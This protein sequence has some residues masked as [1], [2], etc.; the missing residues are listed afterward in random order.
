MHFSLLEKF[1]AAALIC[2]WLLYGAN[3]LGNTLVSVDEH[4]AQLPGAQ[5]QEAGG[6]TAAA[7]AEETGGRSR[8]AAR[9]GR[10]GRRREGVRQVQGLPRRRGRRREQGRAEPAQRRRR[11]TRRHHDDFAYSA[12]L[13]EMEGTWTYENLDK[14]LANPEGLCRRARR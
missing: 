2:A 8:H 9:L 10:S 12:A 3:F 5:P 4:V 1:G 14:F 7:P 11:A 13:A 6:D